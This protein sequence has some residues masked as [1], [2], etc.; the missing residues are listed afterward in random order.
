MSR[1]TPHLETRISNARFD[2]WR[3]L[4]SGGFGEVYEATD[5]ATDAPVAIK[6]LHHDAPESLLHFKHEFRLLSS[7][8]HPH[9]V[10]LYELFSTRGRW[11][12]AMELVP[13]VDFQAWRDDFRR[14][15]P[16]S[17]TALAQV[18]LGLARGLEAIHANALVHLDLKPSNVRVRPDLRPVIL[19][20]GLVR[21]LRRAWRDLAGERP[22]NGG[23]P[24]Y[25]APE[26][27][28]KGSTSPATDIYAA[29]LMLFETL[30]GSHPLGDAAGLFAPPPS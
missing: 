24:R 1:T 6:V 28:W 29:G 11:Y 5:R 19:D 8:V 30:C 23:T 15:P 26:Q 10:T 27:W 21:S 25:M 9:V 18:F 20:F 12:F 7:L 4:G 17:D 2:G 13:G 3:L 16:S 14:A 22:P